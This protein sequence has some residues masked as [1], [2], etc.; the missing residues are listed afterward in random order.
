MRG[1]GVAAL[2]FVS[3]DVSCRQGQLDL[4]SQLFAAFVWFYI[5]KHAT[6]IR[7]IAKLVEREPADRRHRPTQ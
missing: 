7:R 3:V 5:Y 2:Q 4:I 6:T 1:A